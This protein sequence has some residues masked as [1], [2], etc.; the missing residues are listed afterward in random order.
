MAY[1]LKVL[2]LYSIETANGKQTKKDHGFYLR[3]EDIDPEL[4]NSP[5]FEIEPVGIIV[6]EDGSDYLPGIR[7]A[8]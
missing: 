1:A 8:N 7:F 5:V 6:L 4:R 3:E 2:R